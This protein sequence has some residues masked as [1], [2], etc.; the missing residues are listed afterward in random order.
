VTTE[1][2]GAL[3]RK[4][5]IGAGLAMLALGFG[6]CGGG[7]ESLTAAEVAA[8]GDAVCSRLDGEVK[9]VAAEFPQTI[10]FTPEQMQ[11]L[12]QKLVPKVDA[13]IEDFEDLDAPEELEDKLDEAVQQAKADRE[14]LVEAGASPEAAK[15]LFDTGEDP[16]KATNE[17]LAAAGI[18]ACSDD[19]AVTEGDADTEGGTETTTSAPAEESTTTSAP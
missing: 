13:A 6:A 16:F 18:T 5:A 15:A 9:A 19:D 7:S 14:K 10:T 3:V 4:V 1:E 12:W 11:E 2:G 17:K 8:R